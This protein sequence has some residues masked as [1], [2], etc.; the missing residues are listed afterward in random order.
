MTAETVAFETIMLRNNT[1]LPAAQNTTR[2]DL[3]QKDAKKSVTA[4]NLRGKSL[5]KQNAI[6]IV[7]FSIV[8]CFSLLS[9]VGAASIQKRVR[10]NH[11]I[12]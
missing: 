11:D 7:A 10:N 12:I 5:H 9:T 2:V 3:H 4:V 1:T 6:L 8:L